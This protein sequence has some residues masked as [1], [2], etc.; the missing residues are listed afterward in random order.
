MAFLASDHASY[1]NSADVHIAKSSA[2]TEDDHENVRNSSSRTLMLSG[3]GASTAELPS[4]GLMGFP[5]TPLQLQ[6]VG[7]ANV[8]EQ[9]PSST[10]TMAGMSASPHQVAVLTPRARPTGERAATNPV[11]GASFSSR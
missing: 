4:Y 10:L 6:V 3:A 7:S 11:A 1:V 9:T 2:H 8:K 5:I